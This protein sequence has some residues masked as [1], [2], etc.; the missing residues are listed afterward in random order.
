MNHVNFSWRGRF[1]RSECFCILLTHIAH[2]SW[3]L[4]NHFRWSDGPGRTEITDSFLYQLDKSHIGTNDSWL[5]CCWK[6]GKDHSGLGDHL[7]LTTT[8]DLFY[9]TYLFLFIYFYLYILFLLPFCYYTWISLRGLIQVYLIL[10]L[11]CSEYESCITLANVS[12]V[13]SLKTRVVL[14]NW[15]AWFL[16]MKRPGE[17]RVRSACHNKRPRS[18]LSSVDLNVSTSG[19]QATNGNMLFIGFR[20]M[21]GL[22]YST[23]PDSGVLC[24]RLVG[25]GEDEVLLPGVAQASSASVGSAE[26][27]LSKILE[28]VRYIAKRFR[29]QDEEES[30]CNEWKFAASVIDRLCLMAF[31]LFTTLCTTGILMSAPNFVEA[32]SKDFFTW[33]G[34]F[35]VVLT[36]SVSALLGLKTTDKA[37]QNTRI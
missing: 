31:S 15:C 8:S 29:D 2:Q 17:D 36:Q 25:T 4:M 24:S 37:S 27:D 34:V 23:S 10:C 26:P 12:C 3:P 19:P 30:L 5:L 9:L 35:Q 11:F 20:G 16:R 21:D 32:I 22:H 14:L 28:E 13:C 6:Q 33:V 7:A 1:H 18:S